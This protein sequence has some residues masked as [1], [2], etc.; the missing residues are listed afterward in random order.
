[1]ELFYATDFRDGYW[2]P[3][4]T[5]THH[6]S[7]VMRKATG[8]IISLTN[9]AGLQVS[10]KLELNGRQV[11]I[12]ELGRE[13][14]PQAETFCLAIGAVKSAERMEWMVEKLVEIGIRKLQ[15]METENSEISRMQHRRIQMKAV[16]AMKQSLRTHLPEIEYGIP[17][18]Q[19]IGSH[20]CEQGLLAHCYTDMGAKFTPRNLSDRT[21][22]TSVL[23]A[24]G[25]E[26]DFSRAEVELARKAGFDMLDLGN[27]RLRTETA[28]VVACTLFS[29]MNVRRGDS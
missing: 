23:V 3:D 13:E 20:D 5:E 2:Y 15:F 28:A 7:K 24:I 22:P 19:V 4:E 26:G 27:S 6:I 12:L 25:P 16:A 21:R 9:G 18:E 11:R 29:Q 14:L 10:G 1:M 8:E 17:F